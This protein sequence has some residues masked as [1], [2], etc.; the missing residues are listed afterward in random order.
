MQQRTPVST[1]YGATLPL[2]LALALRVARAI[3]ERAQ[4]S[5]LV[6]ACYP[7]ASNEVLA[8]LGH[9]VAC[10]IGNVATLAA[11]YASATG[12]RGAAAAADARASSASRG[13][14]RRAEPPASAAGMDR[15]RGTVHAGCAARRAAAGRPIA[16]R[17]LDFRS[18]HTQV[19]QAV[20]ESV[21]QGRASHDAD[22]D[23]VSRAPLDWARSHRFRRRPGRGRSESWRRA[24]VP[25]GR[26]R[27]S[28]VSPQAGR[29]A[30]SGANAA[31][32]GAAIGGR[33]IGPAR[34]GCGRRQASAMA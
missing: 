4:S 16:R 5:R 34:D 30:G 33:P 10:S 18:A 23:F 20:R 1:A 3:G 19:A 22:P 17:S 6:N 32:C 29:V 26:R 9:D 8:R 12:R 7:D 13:G 28:R 15:R 27:R 2:R 31:A 24:C 11:T 25:C 14:H 21:A